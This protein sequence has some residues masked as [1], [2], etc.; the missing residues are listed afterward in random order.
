MRD[1]LSQYFSKSAVTAADYLR[2]YSE[3][4]MAQKLVD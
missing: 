3:L 2:T 1:F 4:L